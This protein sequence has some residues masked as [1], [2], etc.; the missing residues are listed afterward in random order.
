[1]REDKSGLFEILFALR[2]NP[3][4]NKKSPYERYTGQDA[5]TIKRVLTNTDKPISYTPA[6][7]LSNE[8]SECG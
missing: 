1:M 4:A 8:D 5:N 3:T 7:D 6:F 2:M